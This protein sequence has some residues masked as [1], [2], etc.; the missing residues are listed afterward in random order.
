M[1]TLNKHNKLKALKKS[2]TDRINSAKTVQELE[3]W[4]TT[5]AYHD[6]LQNDHDYDHGYFFDL[7][8]FK[9]RRM[10][11][12]FN[13]HDIVEGEKELAK[14]CDKAISILDAG[15]N[16]NIV[17][18]V[19]LPS[20]VNAKNVHRFFTKAELESISRPGLDKYYLATVREQKAKAL[21]WKYL[22]HHI[23]ELW[24]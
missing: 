11:E 15:Y 19:D 21:F 17:L 23:E 18:S 22:H 14:I 4:K 10:Y 3:G 16:S 1:K 20:K 13:T 2:L 6:V 8:K 5:F 9:L 24:D 12:Y 7:I